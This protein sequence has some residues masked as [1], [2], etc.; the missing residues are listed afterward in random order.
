MLTV[1]GREYKAV[2]RT[3]SFLISLVLMPIMMGG[4]VIFQV[5][6]KDMGSTKE[7]RFAIIDRTA[8]QQ[9]FPYI[10]QSVSRYNNT[11]IIDP[12]TKKQIKSAI[13]VE[14][15]KPGDDRP[16]A[17]SRQRLELSDRVRKKELFGFVDIDADVFQMASESAD[18]AARATPG[19][20][21]VR[22]QSNSPLSREFPNWIEKVVNAAVQDMRCQETGL[23]ADKFKAIQQP[24]PI[25]LKDLAKLDK[26]SGAIDDGQDANF[27]ASFFAPFTLVI[28][29][30]MVIMVGATPLTQGV[31]EEKM[32]RIAEV[33]LGSVKP[34]ELM[35]GKLLGS[36]G[37]SMTL[38]AVYLG[39]GLWV[40]HHFGY[41]GRVPVDVLGWFVVFQI[42]A[43]LLFGS[44]FIAVGAAAN[45]IKESQTLLMPVMLMACL[46]MFAMVNVIEEPDSTFATALSFFPPSTPMLM[47]ARQA[48]PPGVPAWQPIVGCIGLLAM[49]LLCVY[50]AGRIFR[51]GILMQGK[52]A[53]LTDLARWV[54]S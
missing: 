48:V 34:F 46:P 25:A 33:L 22:Y 12:D 28:L 27:L 5:L 10:E 2:V 20:H 54:F 3:K 30:F 23:A 47:V 40:A 4:S 45:D 42:L 37:V 36:V 51:V 14:L 7:K 53:R 49:T 15:V 39:G 43:V 13:A 38:V 31:I 50:A 29:M 17:V 35:M 16:E 32:Q 9:L 1:A 6:L 52:G 24:V 44:L 41:A 18:D 19:R 11:Q 21:G 26:T 8:G